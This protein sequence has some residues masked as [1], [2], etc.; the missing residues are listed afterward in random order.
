MTQLSHAEKV[1]Q[2]EKLSDSNFTNRTMLMLTGV[3]DLLTQEKYKDDRY[4]IDLIYDIAMPE[5][6]ANPEK[7]SK[8]LTAIAFNGAFRPEDYQKLIDASKKASASE[9]KEFLTQEV[10]HEPKEKVVNYLS[11][12]MLA[13]MTKHLKP[14]ESTDI[15]LIEPNLIKECPP[16][17]RSKTF[18]ELMPENTYLLLQKKAPKEL[19]EDLKIGDVIPIGWGISFTGNRTT[20]QGMIVG[21]MDIRVIE[22]M[23]HWADVRDARKKA[24]QSGSAIKIQQWLQNNKTRS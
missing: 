14:W 18:K 19:Q 11:F 10:D 15:L 4:Y 7:P 1:A 24:H 16:D 21:S 12:P 5:L 13:I 8:A 3:E 23:A 6:V 20:D 17:I 9:L 22:A 2:L